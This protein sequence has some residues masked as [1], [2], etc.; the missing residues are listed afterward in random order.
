MRITLQGTQ[1]ELRIVSRLIDQ[2]MIT[3]ALQEISKPTESI[4]CMQVVREERA[5][6]VFPSKPPPA[7]RVKDKPLVTVKNPADSLRPLRLLLDHMGAASYEF[8]ECLSK[9]DGLTEA[10]IKRK[11]K[12]TS[13]G[14]VRGALVKNAMEC[15]L[16]ETDIIAVTASRGKTRLSLTPAFRS[17]LAAYDAET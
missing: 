12:K 6:A 8:V 7:L 4:I 11:L 16:Q 1:E 10:V 5:Q 17:A 9:S 2:P 3:S 15:G 13:I 14:Q